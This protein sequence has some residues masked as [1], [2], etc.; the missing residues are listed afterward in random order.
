MA[1]E[2]PLEE[3]SEVSSKLPTTDIHSITLHIMHMILHTT[4][5]SGSIERHGSM[6]SL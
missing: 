3:R 4:L 1:E 2:S 5:L 6:Q